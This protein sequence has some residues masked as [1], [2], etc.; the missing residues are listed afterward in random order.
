[1]EL[2]TKTMYE[3]GFQVANRKTRIVV[4]NPF[5]KWKNAGV[6]PGK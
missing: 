4:D 1:M 5:S 2:I 6:N 3:I